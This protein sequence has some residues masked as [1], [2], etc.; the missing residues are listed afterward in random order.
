MKIKRALTTTAITTALLTLAGCTANSTY[1]MC[2]TGNVDTKIKS[3]T[4][5]H[6]YKNMM[7]Y[8][9]GDFPTLMCNEF[10]QQGVKCQAYDQVFS[11]LED[12]TDDQIQEGIR[13]GGFDSLM[14]VNDVVSNTSSSNMGSISQFNATNAGGTMT[15]A[16]LKSF[17]RADRFGVVVYDVQTDKR[18]YL[19]KTATSGTGAACV[20]SYVYLRSAA[21]RLAA[22]ILK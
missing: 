15:T 12:Y 6:D 14:F 7:I 8:A 3:Y 17:S 18:I 11:P 13:A 16:N 2:T 1:L 22:D 20:N 4:A 21:E 5:E 19:A 10:K 9:S